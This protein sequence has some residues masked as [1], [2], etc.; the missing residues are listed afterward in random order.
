MNPLL[1]QPKA[2]TSGD[3]NYGVRFVKFVLSGSPGGYS[4]VELVYLFP[5]LEERDAQVREL[6]RH[7]RG[8]RK[9]GPIIET[10]EVEVEVAE[11]EVAE[12]GWFEQIYRRTAL[13]AGRAEHRYGMFRAYSTT[14]L[15][16]DVRYAKNEH[17]LRW[18]LAA[19]WQDTSTEPVEGEPRVPYDVG[20]FV[21][22]EPLR[23]RMVVEVDAEEEEHELGVTS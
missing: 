11:V 7:W 21:A 3:G 13:I 22:D 4:A 10:F 16:Y 12:L 15:T 2:S 14:P 9:S 6:R 5:T 20:F 19:Q 18:M 17:E 8:S 1:H 23:L